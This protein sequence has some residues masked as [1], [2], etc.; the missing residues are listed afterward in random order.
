MRV[1]SLGDLEKA[2]ESGVG[3]RGGIGGAAVGGGGGGGGNELTAALCISLR[4]AP[5]VT[6][7][8]PNID[9]QEVQFHSCS[10]PVIECCFFIYLNALSTAAV[11]HSSHP[12]FFTVGPWQLPNPN[13]NLDALR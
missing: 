7:V 2:G 12:S 6:D 1:I 3:G 5:G 9:W 11:A 8:A 13:C 4:Q 10:L